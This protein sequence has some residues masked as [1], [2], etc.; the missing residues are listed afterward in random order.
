MS[1][2]RFF[3]LIELLIVIAI[4]AILASMLLPALSMAREKAKQSACIGQMKQLGYASQLYADDYKEYIVS[5]TKNYGFDYELRAYFGFPNDPLYVSKGAQRI[6]IMHCPSADPKGGTRSYAIAHKD[7]AWAPA[8]S[9]GAEGKRLGEISKP[10]T[11]ILFCE[12]WSPGNSVGN[13]TEGAICYPKDDI[14]SVGGLIARL[15]RKVNKSN[16]TF[17]DGHCEYLDYRR[18]TTLYYPTVGNRWGGMWTI[19]PND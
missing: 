6:R 10:G 3:T 1:I 11:T 7:P 15:H 16:Y 18:T 2:Q 13:S 9:Y 8:G 5:N 17:V 19:N 14:H 12:N 4:I